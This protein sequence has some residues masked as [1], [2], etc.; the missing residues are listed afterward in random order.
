MVGV[1]GALGG[2]LVCGQG[3]GGGRVARP[4]PLGGLRAHSFPSWM[5]K[6]G[7]GRCTSTICRLEGLLPLGSQTPTKSPRSSTVSLAARAERT[8]KRLFSLA[9]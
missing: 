7:G 9:S 4:R 1:W 6:T 8:A 2:Q 5:E 3:G